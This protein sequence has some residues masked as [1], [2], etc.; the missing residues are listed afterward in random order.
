MIVPVGFLEQETKE[1]TMGLGN[2]SRLALRKI[3]QTMNLHGLNRLGQ[4]NLF[5]PEI[6]T[7]LFRKNYCLCVPKKYYGGRPKH[8]DQSSVYSQCQTLCPV[9]G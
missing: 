6:G 8:D 1:L 4:I 3:S 7:L 9:P 5:S 2:N